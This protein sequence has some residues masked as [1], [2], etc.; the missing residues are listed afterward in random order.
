MDESRVSSC[1]M[2]TI[3]DRGRGS[4]EYEKGRKRLNDELQGP[5]ISGFPLAFLT[6]FSKPEPT[7]RS[8]FNRHEASSPFRPSSF[9]GTILALFH[10]KSRWWFPHIHRI[11]NRLYAKVLP[12][13]D[14]PRIVNMLLRSCGERANQIRLAERAEAKVG[15]AGCEGAGARC[16]WGDFRPRQRCYTA[17]RSWK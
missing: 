12:N 7:T 17:V 6:S 11:S 10:R 13:H 16:G 5:D 9:W 14:R 8:C 1:S 2:S 4:N 15:W 3:G